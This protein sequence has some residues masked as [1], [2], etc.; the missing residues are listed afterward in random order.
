MEITAE[1]IKELREK[2]NAGIMDCKKAL[3]ETRGDLEKAVAFLRQKGLAIAQKRSGRSTTEGLVEA[4]I[5][6]GGKIGVLLEVN[7]ETDFVAKTPAF[8]ELVKNLAMQIAATNPLCVR[9][10]ELAPELIEKE[11]A[12]FRAQAQENGKP[13]KVVEKIVEGRL[14]KFFSEACLLDQPYVKNPELLVQDYLN[15]VIAQVGEK[16]NIRRFTRYQL[17]VG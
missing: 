1:R 15:Q 7:C 9:R 17:G 8:Q 12:I 11:K 10:E 6:F 2:T 3:K 5:H 16:V 14:Q 4:Y 13:E